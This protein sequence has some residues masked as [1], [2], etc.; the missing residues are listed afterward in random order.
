M[1]FPSIIAYLVLIL[2]APAYNCFAYESRG[3]QTYFTAPIRFRDV[4]LGK[5]LLLVAVLFL[6]LATSILVFAFRV[7][8]PS[9]PRFVATLAAIIFITIGQLAI[10]N[11]SSLSFPRRLEFGQMRNQ[12]QSGMAVLVAFGVQITLAGIST[13][14]LF[15]GKWTGNVWL[16]TEAFTMLAAVAVAGYF[17]SLDPLNHLAESKRETLIETLTR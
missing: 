5:N 2:L 9:P 3:I 7:G 17:A 10:A 12:R 13:L 4:L 16:P 8:L 14:I 15:A 6:E 11:W 1:F